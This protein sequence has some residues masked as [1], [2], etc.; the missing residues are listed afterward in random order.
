MLLV[1]VS[2]FGVRGQARLRCT[3]G[4]DQD[5]GPNLEK[6]KPGEETNKEDEDRH[7]LYNLEWGVSFPVAVFGPVSMFLPVA[8][9]ARLPGLLFSPGSRVP[10]ISRLAFAGFPT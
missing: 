6:F 9:F 4:A 5:E 3:L 8:V 2:R 7:P 10:C 1:P